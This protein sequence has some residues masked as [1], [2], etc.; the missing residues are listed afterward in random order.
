MIVA[1][2]SIKYNEIKN[3]IGFQSKAKIENET[4]IG[5]AKTLLNINQKTIP[6]PLYPPILK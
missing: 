4:R 6:T 5:T 3:G 1:R 2:K